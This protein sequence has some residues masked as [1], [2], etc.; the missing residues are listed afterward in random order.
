MSYRKR[1]DM[2][3]GN[4]P[5]AH[6]HM[7]LLRLLFYFPR[8]FFRY[9]SALIDAFLG[10]LFDGFAGFLRG[11]L[12]LVRRILCGLRHAFVIFIGFL[13]QRDPCRSCEQCPGQEQTE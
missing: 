12:R 3:Y 4:W 8:A 7:A 1:F 2:A 5:M 9:F 13:R 6:W 11:I 10:S